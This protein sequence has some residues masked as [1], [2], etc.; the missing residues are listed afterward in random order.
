MEPAF[1]PFLLLPLDSRFDARHD[2][3]ETADFGATFRAV[4]H[5]VDRPR[6]IDFEGPRS[7][8]RTNQNI[9]LFFRRHARIS[10]R[11]CKEYALG[12]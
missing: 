3:I 1:A 9:F 11:R 4:N 8:L 7:A 10:A 5:G 2:L 6:V 12:G